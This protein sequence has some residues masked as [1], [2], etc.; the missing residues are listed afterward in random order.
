MRFR[1]AGQDPINGAGVRAE[2]FAGSLGRFYRRY[3][4]VLQGNDGDRARLDALLTHA[5]RV[6]A[7]LNRIHLALVTAEDRCSA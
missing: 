6:E 1:S 3:H 4:L 2:G 7:A 5:P